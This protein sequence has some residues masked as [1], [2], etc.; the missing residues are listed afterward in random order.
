MLNQD[1][2]VNYRTGIVEIGQGSPFGHIKIV[3]EITGIPVDKIII[4]LPDTDST[5]NAKPTHGSRGLMMGGTAAAKAALM[6]RENM[7][8]CAAELFEIPEDRI[9]LR[10]NKAYDKKE[11]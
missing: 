9:E 1:G 2:S 8:K 5:L 4:D 6:L 11:T 3:S 10:E 7:V